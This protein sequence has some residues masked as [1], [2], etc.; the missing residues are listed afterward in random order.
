VSWNNIWWNND[1]L[2]FNFSPIHIVQKEEE[3]EQDITTVLAHCL[4]VVVVLLLSRNQYSTNK[5]LL[6]KLH[7]MVINSPLLILFKQ[8]IHR[9]RWQLWIIVS[10][11]NNTIIQHILQLSCRFNSHQ[12][13]YKKYIRKSIFSII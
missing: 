9:F 5:L 8:H 3:G 10:H 2:N 12:V 6:Y 11:H 7:L 1:D 4:V 13:K